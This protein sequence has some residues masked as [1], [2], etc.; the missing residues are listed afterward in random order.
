M[1]SLREKILDYALKTYGTAPEYPWASAPRYCVL[2]RAD[3]RKWYALVMD[4]PYARLGLSRPGVTDVLNL[5]LDPI[6]VGS[7]RTREGYLPAYHMHRGNWITILLDG[8]VPLEELLPLVDLSYAAAGDRGAP[9]LVRRS[10][11]V[12]ANPKYYDLRAG[13]EENQA[14]LFLWKQSS[15]VAVGDTVYLYVAA[16]FSAIRY[17]CE[18]VE[19]DIPH[20]SRN[21]HVKLTR[22]MRLRLLRCYDDPPI[23]LET[24]R[25]HGVY[26]VRGPRGIPRSLIEEIEHQYGE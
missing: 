17:K 23:G 12:P 26:A 14:G 21:P 8:T 9:S 13:I 2:R 6:L 15:K 18:A 3:N 25:A 7:L 24:L 5:K 4:I 20:R 1:I 10:W 16:P 19:V 22:V 11:L